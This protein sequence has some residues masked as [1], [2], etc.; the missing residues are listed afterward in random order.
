MVDGTIE[1]RATDFLANNVSE[2]LEGLDL[3]IMLPH[4]ALHS[5]LLSAE[6]VSDNFARPSLIIEPHIGDFVVDNSPVRTSP[7]DLAS[8]DESAWRALES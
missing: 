6:Q 8:S 3:P 7:E 2:G 1:F 4:S 5:A